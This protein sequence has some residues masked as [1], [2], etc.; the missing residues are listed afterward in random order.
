[1]FKSII[2]NMRKN[3]IV[4]SVIGIC[5]YALY[6]RIVFL[7]SHVLWADELMQLNQ[8]NGTFRQLFNYLPGSTR[9][10]SGDYYLMYPFYKL[11]SYNKWGL[12]IPHIILTI[13]G[14]FIFYLICKRYYKSIWGFLISFSVICFNETLIRHA[15]EI[16]PYAVLPTLILAIF[17]LPPSKFVLVIL[18]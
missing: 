15:T 1:M 16:R 11:F 7:G 6:L 4:V 14:F 17:Y 5:S 2:K 10:L 13:V 3:A 9:F 18:N 8:M 12:A